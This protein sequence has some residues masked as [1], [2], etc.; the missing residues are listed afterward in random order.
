M[1]DK[2][3]RV[4]IEAYSDYDRGVSQYDEN[5]HTIE[6]GN[7]IQYTDYGNLSGATEVGELFN[8]KKSNSKAKLLEA[9]MALDYAYAPLDGTKAE[10]LDFLYELKLEDALVKIMQEAKDKKA[11]IVEI[12]P[13]KGSGQLKKHVLRFM[14]QK[15]KGLYHRIEKD[16][17][18][19]GRIFIHLR[20]QK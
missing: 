4:E 5:F 1:N 13:G 3:L 20:W 2:K 8:I 16:D 11:K 12:I 6:A 9:C 10:L 19:W 18:N 17:K 14:E 15:Y 7:I